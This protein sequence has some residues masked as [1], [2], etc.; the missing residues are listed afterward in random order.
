VYRDIRDKFGSLEDDNNL[1]MFFSEVLARR[2][3]LE[4]EDT[5]DDG[6]QIPL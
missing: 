1:M 6:V 4:D 5:E 2:D 3:A